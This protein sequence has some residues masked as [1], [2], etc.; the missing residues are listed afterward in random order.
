LLRN[1]VNAAAAGK[2]LASIDENNFAAG[3]GLLE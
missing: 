1:A 2:D 3:I